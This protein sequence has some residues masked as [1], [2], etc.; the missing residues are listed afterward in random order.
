MN[1]APLSRGWCPSARRP[2]ATGDGLL[3]RL[4]PRGATLTADQARDVAEAARAFGNGLLDISARGNLQ[5]RGVSEATHGGLMDRLAGAG[6]AGPETGSG[7]VTIVSPLAG[8]DPGELVDVRDLAR[9]IEDE[10]ARIPRLPAKIAVVLDGG[11]RLALDDVEA[12]IRLVAMEAGGDPALA[13]ALASSTGSVWVGSMTPAQAPSIVP[14]LLATFA[15]L[16]GD[17]RTGVQRIRDLP[18]SSW[19]GLLEAIGLEPPRIPLPRPRSP[20]V[21]VVELADDRVALLMAFPFGRCNAETL[22]RIAGWSE[23][24][25]DGELRLSP[26]RGVALPGVARENAPTLMRAAEAAGL[27]LDPA[28]PRLAVAACPG[29]PACASATTPTREDAA[30]LADAARPLIAAGGTLHVSGC[31]KGCAHPRP[32]AL[33]LV[34]GDG[35]YGVVLEGSPRDVPT[36]RFSV[37]EIVGRLQGVRAPADLAGAFA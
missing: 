11:G 23:I 31:A 26:W 24:L 5:I 25:G 36:A 17:G 7:S 37:E 10:A 34:G 29:A 1:A 19:L 8:S 21:G 9:R 28:D 35:A 6:L 30:R 32:A 4:H 27:I 13:L 20:R 33:T 15:S 14:R 2:M 16:L 3:V 18:P 12:D 22:T